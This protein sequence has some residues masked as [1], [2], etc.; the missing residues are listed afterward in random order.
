[1]GKTGQFLWLAVVI[2]T[3]FLAWSFILCMTVDLFTSDGSYAPS[4]TTMHWISHSAKLE[5]KLWWFQ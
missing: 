4:S 2:C 1:M 3:E 5:G